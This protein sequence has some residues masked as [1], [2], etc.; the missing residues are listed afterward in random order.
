MILS[1]VCFMSISL[2][3]FGY[4]SETGYIGE[5]LGIDFYSRIDENTESTIESLR[6]N[7]LRDYGTF[8]GF[9]K[10]CRASAAWLDDERM[11]EQILIDATRGAF[12]KLSDIARRK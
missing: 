11:D 7:R 4:A 1:I 3:F 5:K 6:Q 8:R 10:D 12:G 9:G 2:P